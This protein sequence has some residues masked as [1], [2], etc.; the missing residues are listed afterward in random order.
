MP[1]GEDADLE[2]FLERIAQVITLGRTGQGV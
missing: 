2:E 1:K